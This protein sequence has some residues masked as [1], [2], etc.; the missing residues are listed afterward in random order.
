MMPR[1]TLGSPRGHVTSSCNAYTAEPEKTL[2][3]AADKS[4]Q[5]HRG[6]RETQ[7]LNS[8]PTPERPE[9]QNLPSLSSTLPPPPLQAPRVCV[10]HRR[11]HRHNSTAS[12]PVEPKSRST[13]G[14]ESASPRVTRSERSTELPPPQHPLSCH[15]CPRAKSGGRRL[16][17]APQRGASPTLTTALPGPRSAPTSALRLE[18]PRGRCC[19]PPGWMGGSE[20]LSDR[21]G[22]PPRYDPGPLS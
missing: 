18:R 17:T 8:G 15:T 5:D 11:P 12:Q 13:R 7:G 20:S 21:G 16:L 19:S 14:S 3:R 10:L 22:R 1:Q 2:G 9:R 6:C 4:C